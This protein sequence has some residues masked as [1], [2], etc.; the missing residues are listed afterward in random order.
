METGRFGLASCLLAVEKS[1][2][3]ASLGNKLDVFRQTSNTSLISEKAKSPYAHAHAHAHAHPIFLFSFPKARYFNL[4]RGP[5]VAYL[6]LHAHCPC[7][8]VSNLSSFSFSNQL[9]PAPSSTGSLLISPPYSH[10][11][12]A[13]TTELPRRGNHHV[14]NE[15]RPSSS[16]YHRSPRPTS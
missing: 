8:T 14:F 3:K 1:S 10:K 16:K 11:F 7:R 12:L 2:V 5:A 13:S 15:R 6:E 4:M 9:S